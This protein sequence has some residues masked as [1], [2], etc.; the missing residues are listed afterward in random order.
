MDNHQAVLE[1]PRLGIESYSPGYIAIWRAP[2]S[3]PSLTHVPTSQKLA[4]QV[5]TQD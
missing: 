3:T 1:S 2:H 4:G 5:I